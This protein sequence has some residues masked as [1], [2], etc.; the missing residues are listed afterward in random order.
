MTSA[1]NSRQLKQLKAVDELYINKL[2]PLEK[3]LSQ[4]G[5]SKT[6]YYR[7]KKMN[8]QKG[9]NKNVTNIIENEQNNDIEQDEGEAEFN[10]IKSL[11]KSGTKQRQIQ[12]KI[13]NDK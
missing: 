9:G 13:I 3:A 11:L 5:I 2:Y 1:L 10:K 6:S 7:F 12:R 8:V 4:V